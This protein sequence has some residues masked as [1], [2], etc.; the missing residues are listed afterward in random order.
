VAQPEVA[1]YATSVHAVLIRDMGMTLGELFVLDEL[2]AA[3]EQRGDWAFFFTA[4]PLRVVGGVG[5][6]IT[7]LAIL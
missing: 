4:S 7:P 5:S 2:A 1:G 6:P 3:C